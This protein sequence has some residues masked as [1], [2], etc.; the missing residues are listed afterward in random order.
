MCDAV[1]AE[2]YYIDDVAV[3][4]FVLPLYFTREAEVGSR[5]D[6][7]GRTFGETNEPLASFGVNPGGYIGF[8]NPETRCHET[9]SLT[10]DDLAR[11]RMQIKGQA[12]RT[13]RSVRYARGD[14]PPAPPQGMQVIVVPQ[15]STI[16]VINSSPDRPGPGD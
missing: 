13:R 10:D 5:N 3:S 15:R 4:N 6:F 14:A 7:L 9:V 8:F 16:Q 2:H 11:K 1:Q 12:Q